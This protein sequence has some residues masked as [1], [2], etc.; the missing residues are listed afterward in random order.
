MQCTA[1]CRRA[2]QT[3][4]WIPDEKRNKRWLHITW[5]RTIWRNTKLIRHGI[6][7]HMFQGFGQKRMETMDCSMCKSLD[8]LMQDKLIFR[9]EDSA[10]HVLF[11][12]YTWTCQTELVWNE[13]YPRLALC[14]V[15]LCCS[16]NLYRDY[17]Y[18][19]NHHVKRT[20]SSNTKH[21]A[22]SL[23]RVQYTLH[24]PDMAHHRT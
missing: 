7:R 11:N 3:P 10:F 14:C 1:S 12:I 13:C 21:C 16:Y 24:N 18:Q 19:I 17:S 9:H 15:W 5:Q 6:W 20:F 23:H 8:G 2:K 22:V 4:H